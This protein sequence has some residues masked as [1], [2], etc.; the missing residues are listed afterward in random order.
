MNSD[1]VLTVCPFCGCGCQFYLQVM[2]GEITGVVP[3]KTDEVSEGKPCIKV[4]T[5]NMRSELLGEIP[6]LLDGYRVIVEETG[7]FRALST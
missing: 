1:F 5:T 4:F 7:E 3:C 2:D 6:T